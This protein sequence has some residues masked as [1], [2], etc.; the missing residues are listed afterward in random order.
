MSV[1]A[2]EV[3]SLKKVISPRGLVKEDFFEV[4]M[5]LW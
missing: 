4:N 2:H 3:A 5:E 1:L